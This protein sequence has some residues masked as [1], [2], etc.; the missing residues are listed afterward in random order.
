MGQVFQ[1]IRRPL[2]VFDPAMLTIL[3]EAYDKALA[4][5]RYRKQPPIVRET[6]AVR[7]FEIGV[8]RRAR[9]RTFVP[10]RA[11]CPWLTAVGRLYDRAHTRLNH[12]TV[13]R[14]ISTP[15]SCF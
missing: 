8:A 7:I 15:P 4:S 13:P 1:F 10:R 3:G 11:C 9:P 2:D 14:A 5:L 12:F 6:M